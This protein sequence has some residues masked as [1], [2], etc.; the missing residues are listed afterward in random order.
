MPVLPFLPNR[1]VPLSTQSR[2]CGAALLVYA[3]AGLVITIVLIYQLPPPGVEAEGE[4][5]MHRGLAVVTVGVISALLGVVM[6]RVSWQRSSAVLLSAKPVTPQ[7]VQ[8]SSGS[9]DW[10]WAGILT[11][12]G[13]GMVG[14]FTE[15]AFI[16]LTLG[17]VVLANWG[18]AALAVASQVRRFEHM[19][20][21]RY[22]CLAVSRRSWRMVWIRPLQ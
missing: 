2:V 12:V 3:F 6:S 8:R 7:S 10:G 9:W 14:A 11:V 1:S 22:Y 5:R 19:R 18:A 13:I 21:V 17:S 4:G 16:D 15:R 20:R